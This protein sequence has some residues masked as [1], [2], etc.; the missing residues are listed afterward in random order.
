MQLHAASN[1]TLAAP[2]QF[3]SCCLGRLL[4]ALPDTRRG[5]N[6]DQ[7]LQL[8]PKHIGSL[9]RD[10]DEGLAFLGTAKPNSHRS[11]APPAPSSNQTTCTRPSPVLLA[12][13]RLCCT[14]DRSTWRTQAAPLPRCRPCTTKAIPEQSFPRTHARKCL[15]KALLP[16]R[17][18]QQLAT[19]F[20]LTRGANEHSCAS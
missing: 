20:P 13:R 5:K 2:W 3:D 4:R 1:N 7:D 17:A 8:W 9:T 12:V 11:Q 15:D 10:I 6:R 16:V 14:E 19:H 18:L